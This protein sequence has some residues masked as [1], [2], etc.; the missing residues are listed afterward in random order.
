MTKRIFALFLCAALAFAADLPVKQIT[1]Y[2]HGIAY[3][4]REGSVA[5]GEE[6]RLDFKNTDMNDVLK[7]LTV[8]DRSGGRIT[9]IRYD[10]NATL[11][12]QLGKF[13]FQIGQG[14]MLS[15]FLD[16]LKGSRLQ[17]KTSEGVLSG[18]ILS[19][20]SVANS[21]RND[22]QITDEQLTLLLDSGDVENIDLRRITSLHFLDARLQD[23][24]KQY[25]QTIAKANSRDTR[26][27]YIDSAS[28]AG[29]DLRISYITPAAIWKSSYRLALN[30][31]AATLEGWA[32]V[33]NTT[34]EDWNSVK[35]SVVSGRPI[36]FIS[37]LDRPRFG[38]RQVAELPEDRAA[39]PEVYSGSVDGQTVGERNGVVGGTGM[40]GGV[41]GGIVG[42]VPGAA[43]PP[44]ARA[45]AFVANQ[46]MAPRAMAQTV[47]VTSDVVGATGSVLG[48]L[49]EYNFATPV[50]IKH[51]QS[52][53]LPF[54]SDKVAARKLLIYTSKDGEHPVNA[55]EVT[56]ST[57]KTLDGGPITVYDAGAYA[58]EALV[59]TLKGGDKRLIGYAVD[60]GTRITN[61]FD[62]GDEH[63]LEVH[64]N[65]GILEMKSSERDHRTY[66]IKNVDAKAK[67]LIIQQDGLNEYTVISPKPVEQTATAYRFEVRL[68]ANGTQTLK[69]E[70][71]KV[72]SDTLA[73]ASSGSDRLIEV[74]QNK[75]L[76]AEGRQQL[77]A[78]V[79]LKQQI[80]QTQATL[81]S[82]K[83]NI[84]ELTQDQSRLR[85]NIDSLNKVKGQEDQVRQYSAKLNDNEVKLAQL[86]DQRTELTH[87]AARQN[88]ELR[89]AIAH[90]NF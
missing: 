65:N 23:Q 60:Y 28:D 10:S 73:V 89:T 24:L 36:S 20:R 35:L 74:I 3:I 43:P 38:N 55:A 70:E 78:I 22:T 18:S 32:I 14:E 46:L 80:A 48:E 31:S 57:D 50:T 59:E 66:E 25:L 68:P 67:T 72:T 44:P 19:A 21:G 6:A 27:V 8:S 53:M 26:S 84:D 1:L 39:G 33:D 29:R 34:D 52:A 85:Q 9:G 71:E 86:R 15:A 37:L 17:V 45:K 40:A 58:G 42:G 5:S 62:N 75:K 7:S 47:E 83:S 12:Q 41:L 76:S 54:L 16:T 64:S 51:N 90:L 61:N 49:F 79:D 56:N 82:G 63:L 69:V 81:D 88:A 4:Q 30:E 2:K 11:E 87:T 77:Q 13:P